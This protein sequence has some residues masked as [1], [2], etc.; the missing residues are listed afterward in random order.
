M[1]ARIVKCVICG[2]EYELEDNDP[3]I[4]LMPYPHIHCKHC[5]CWITLF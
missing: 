2:T 3:D 5:G 1:K 4:L